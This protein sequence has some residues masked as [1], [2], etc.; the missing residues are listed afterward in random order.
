MIKSVIVQMLRKMSFNFWYFCNPPWDTGISPPELMSYIDLHP[1]G[2]A[3]DLGCG[4]GTNSIT[5]AKHGWEV[6]GIDFAYRAIK[7]ARKKA[8]RDGVYAEFYVDDV[9]RLRMI[10]GNFDLILDIGCFHSI[11]HEFRMHYLANLERLLATNGTYMLY[12]FLK[13]DP[14]SESSGVDEQEIH[15]I[16]QRLNLINR[17]DG[18]ERGLRPSTWVIFRKEIKQ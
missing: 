12:A 14:Q 1:P 8:R 6:V 2:R 5:L 9:T 17:K 15:K 3:L 13:T 4:T 18:S 11:A 7:I 16:S 10:S